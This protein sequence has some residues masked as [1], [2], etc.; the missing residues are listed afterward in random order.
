MCLLGSRAG[1]RA[2]STQL[3]PP[4]ARRPVC[5]RV[6]HQV[7]GHAARGQPKDYC[8]Y[9]VRSRRPSDAARH[10][11]SAATYSSITR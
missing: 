9:I 3:P 10:N 5:V 11:N 4:A 2:P 1:S 6:S 8:E 7:N